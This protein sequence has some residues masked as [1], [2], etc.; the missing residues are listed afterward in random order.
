MV[1]LPSLQSTA[2]LTAPSSS[3]HFLFCLLEIALNFKEHGNECFS[4]K[5][6]REAIGFYTQGIDVKPDDKSLFE[7]LYVNRAA[8]NLALSMWLFPTSFPRSN[9]VLSLSPS[10]KQP[11]SPTRLF[12]RSRLERPIRQGALP[13]LPCPAR[14]GTIPR[15]GRLL[16]ARACRSRRGREQAGEDV[17]GDC[18]R[19]KVEI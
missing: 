8:C 17:V 6:Y 18:A 11:E 9:L 1:S 7:V 5:Q 19:T 12:R 4:L 14:I 16:S 15:S 2:H 13:I 10:R 3:F